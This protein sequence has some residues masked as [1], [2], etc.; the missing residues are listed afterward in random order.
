M[1][2]HPPK[3]AIWRQGWLRGPAGSTAGFPSTLKIGGSLLTRPDWPQLIRARVEE[4]DPASPPLLV[5]GGGR[6]VDGLRAIDAVAPQ[7]V[8]IVHRLAI[9][10]MGVTARLVAE[11]VGL[12]LV[13][14]QRISS[15]AVLDVSLWIEAEGR[16]SRLPD[17]WDVTSDS[18]AAAV[19]E[20]RGGTLV[21]A[22]SLPPPGVAA[23]WSLEQLAEA[24]WVDGFFPEAAKRIVAIA[25]CCPDSVPPP[26][27]G[28]TGLE[29]RNS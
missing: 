26:A 7:P 11:A 28:G 1:S 4:F 18:I 23:A 27:V 2:P 25:W 8:R 22:K 20:E 19:A 6:I 24:G 10:L 15:A 9:D 21:L 12:P 16:G 17:G 13:G 5:V 29:C 3:T 14:D